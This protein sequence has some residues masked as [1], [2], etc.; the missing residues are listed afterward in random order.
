[1]KNNIHFVGIGGIGMSGIARVML[2]MGHKVSGSDL[3]ANG[4]T[5]ALESIGATIFE[6]HRPSNVLKDTGVLVYSSSVS[7]ENPELA[8][9]RKRRIKIVHRAQM[10][11]EIFNSKKELEN[12]LARPVKLFCYPLGG[13]N[14]RIVETVKKAGYLGACVTNKAKPISKFRLFE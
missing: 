9:A 14:A 1:M 13:R 11:G 12:R 8:E 2:D 4:L 6:G 5:K 10:L 7:K 3:A